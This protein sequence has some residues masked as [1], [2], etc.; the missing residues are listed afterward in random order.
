MSNARIVLREAA[1]PAAA[2]I[3]RRLGPHELAWDSG[4]VRK[5]VLILVLALAW[6]AYGTVLDNPLLFPTLTETLASLFEH[7]ADGSLPARACA[8]IQVLLMGY[9]AGLALAGVLTSSPSTGASAR[10]C[11]TR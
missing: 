5:A 7:V 2:E 8:S 9:A 6:Q 4:F 10:T 11:S 1:G 3:E